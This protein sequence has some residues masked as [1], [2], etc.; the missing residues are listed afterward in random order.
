MAP[1]TLPFDLT[2]RSRVRISKVLMLMH[3]SQ[4][5]LGVLVIVFGYHVMKEVALFNDVVRDAYSKAYYPSVVV[6]CGVYASF[7]NICTLQVR[8][9]YIYRNQN[10]PSNLKSCTFSCLNF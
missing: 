7:I 6:I 8:I 2:L 10:S 1:P 3:F 9:L 4:L 5:T